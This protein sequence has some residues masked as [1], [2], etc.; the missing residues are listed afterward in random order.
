MMASAIPRHGPEVVRS[1][2]ASWAGPARHAGLIP[3]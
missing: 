3:A 2:L 1:T